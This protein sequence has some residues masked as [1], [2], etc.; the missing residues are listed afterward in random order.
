MTRGQRAERYAEQSCHVLLRKIGILTRTGNMTDN[1]PGLQG[2]GGVAQEQ[3]MPRYP[4]QVLHRG[5]GVLGKPLDWEHIRFKRE[6]TSQTTKTA[7]QLQGGPRLSC[8]SD[9]QDILVGTGFLQHTA[10]LIRVRHVQ[11]SSSGQIYALC[12]YL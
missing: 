4:G 9:G 12:S 8:Q 5:T 2:R 3:L 1:I 10:R 7:R 11:G 6:P